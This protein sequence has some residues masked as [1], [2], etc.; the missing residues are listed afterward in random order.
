[1]S[2]FQLKLIAF[3][4]MIADHAG[5]VFFPDIPIFRIIGRISF[6]IF[7]FLLVEGFFHTRNVF[8]YFFRMLLMGILSEPLFDMLFF[9]TWFEPGYNN[10][11]FT[12]CIGLMCMTLYSKLQTGIEKGVAFAAVLC[13]TSY[14]PSDYGAYGAAIIGCFY[15]FRKKRIANL[16]AQTLITAILG[17]ARIQMFSVAGCALTMCY[18]RERGIQKAGYLFYLVYPVHL[19]ILW[20]IQGM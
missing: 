14:I 8:K 19:Y 18:N 16:G 10:V 17:G 13:L 15:F 6:P 9:G 1:M 12:L 20:K 11:F 3:A 4:T 2:G 7:C 5:A